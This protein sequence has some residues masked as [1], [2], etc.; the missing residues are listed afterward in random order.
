MSEL[1]NNE[2]IKWKVFVNNTSTKNTLENFKSKG[3]LHADIQSGSL[4]DVITFLQADNKYKFIIAEVIDTTSALQTIKQISEICQNGTSLICLGENQDIKF[5]RSLIKAGVDEYHTLPLVFPELLET[6]HGISTND[7]KNETRNNS[8]PAIT[9]IGSRGGLGTSTIAT[10]LAWLLSSDFH[11]QT[12]LLDMDIH[13]G[14]TAL[15]LDLDPNHGLTQA[16]SNS[17][18]LDEVFLR[19]LTLNATDNLSV[20]AAEQRLNNSVDIDNDSLKSLLSITR[21]NFDF[22]VIDLN[23]NNLYSDTIL[24]NSTD[25]VVLVEFSLPSIRDTAKILKNIAIKSPFAKVKIAAIKHTAAKSAELTQAQ[26]E[27]GISHPIDI[28]LPYDKKVALE[29]MNFGQLLAKKYPNHTITKSLKELLGFVTK[30]SLMKE[31][32]SWLDKLLAWRK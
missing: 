11:S 9:I 23:H 5:Y 24:A 29:S 13:S 27:E 30:S 19:R 32:S 16:L 1:R 14:T 31:K 18:R 10:N 15:M 17:E 4:K 22:T 20:L 12:C 21:N 6:I 2:S 26:F 8:N 7:E 3:V 25:L 28:I